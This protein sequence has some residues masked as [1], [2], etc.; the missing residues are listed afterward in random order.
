MVLVIGSTLTRL[1]TIGAFLRSR[2][3]LST[4]RALFFYE[5]NLAYKANRNLFHL[6]VLLS[7]HGIKLTPGKFMS[8]L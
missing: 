1:A 5:R 6:G 7:W 2:E 8:T 4:D 3:P